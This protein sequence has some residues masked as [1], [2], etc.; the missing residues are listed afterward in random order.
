MVLTASVRQV[1][2]SRLAQVIVL[3]ARRIVGILPAAVMPAERY[4]RLAAAVHERLVRTD[5]LIA[6]AFWRG[7]MS[8]ILPC[9]F[10]LRGGRW[11]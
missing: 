8:R 1:S 7:P 9:D 3:G 6:S 11:L 5:L 4:A 10:D 2:G